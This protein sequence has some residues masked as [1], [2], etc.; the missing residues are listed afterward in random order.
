MHYAYRPG[1]QSNEARVYVFSTKRLHD[2]WLRDNREGQSISEAEA[3]QHT[4]A[5]VWVEDESADQEA[6]VVLARER[7]N[8]SKRLSKYRDTLLADW[9]DS[10]HW[11]YVA[12]STEKELIDWVKAIE[13]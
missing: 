8:G 7:V 2:A 3:E 11:Q 12:T 13:N 4:E 6:Y 10:G 9:N 5:G 1:D